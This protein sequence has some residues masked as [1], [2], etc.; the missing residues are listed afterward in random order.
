MISSASTATCHSPRS[1]RPQLEAGPVRGGAQRLGS[2][3]ARWPVCP[4]TSCRR[5][6]RTPPT[7]RRVSHRL[8]VRAGLIRQL[9]A[10]LWTWLPGRL[11][12]REAGRGGDPR[13]DRRDRRPGDADAG[14]AAG[15]AV[16]ADRPLRRS[17]SCS[18]STTARDRRA[19]ARDDPRGGAS[20]S[21]S[22]REIRSYRELPKILYHLQ[23]KER[24]E[25]R[26]RAGVLRTREFT[27]KDSY[28]LRP[29]RR[30]ARRELRAAPSRLRA[31]PR[32]L[33]AALVRGRVRRRDDGRVG[34]PRVHGARAP[35]ART[36]SRSRPATP[37]TSRSPRRRRS[38]SSCRRRSTSRAR[39]RRPG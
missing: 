19:R 8:M 37:P 3:A 15:R 6:A 25:P 13:G 5:C 31:H 9:G 4:P 16:E 32:P 7:P 21:T 1:K 30:G 20:P 26:P 36:R 34:R 38:R 28:S 29:R 11:P 39:C 23:V 24:D 14:A 35:R 18:S 27:M 22:P 17:T 2:L 12:D 33:R 10:G